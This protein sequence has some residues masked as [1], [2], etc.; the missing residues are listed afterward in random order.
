MDNFIVSARKYRP[1]TFASVVGQ[2]HITS[3][4]K[5]AISRRQ[6][7]HAYLFCGPRGVGK[8][9]CARIFA[10]AINCL[11]PGPDAEACNECESCRAFN[12]GRSFN[13]HE[14]DAASNNSV[15]DIRNLTDQVRIP[16]QIGR[17][18]VYIIDEVHM[19]SV[20]AFNAFLKTLEEPPRNVCIL[21]GA[22]TDN[23]LLP[24]V[25]SRVKRLDVPPFSD[26]EIKRAL[27]DEY[28][29][30]AKLESA[31]ALGGGKIG[32]VIKAYTDGNAEKMQTFCRE[33]LFSMRSSK[34]VAK[35][36]SKINKDNIKDF[37]SILKSEV[38]NLLVKDNRK[39]ED[40]GY[41]TG[42]LIAIS[43]MLSEKERALYYNAN[44][45]MV[46]DSVLLAILGEKYKW[47]KL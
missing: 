24:T 40:Y 37:I 1:A 4:L 5:N 19:L 22:T 34:D 3:T 36:S 29:D 14:L 17:Y 41:V 46:A 7:A 39:A 11:N 13:I 23:A 30:K 10:K 15:D 31:I 33:V 26:G 8:T 47:Q 44:A 43:D 28:P 20:Q 6:L 38:A 25:K 12:E 42:A 18:S 27:G 9:T 2:S 32:S 45:V 16:P 21:I 35:Y